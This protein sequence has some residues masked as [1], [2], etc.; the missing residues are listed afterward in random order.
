VSLPVC[1][2]ESAFGTVATMRRK[3]TDHQRPCWSQ[4]AI[5]AGMNSL[6][7]LKLERPWSVCHRA[8]RSTVTPVSV[9]QSAPEITSSREGPERLLNS[10]MFLTIR[11]ST[12]F[13]ND[14]FSSNVVVVCVA[15]S[16][17]MVR[18]TCENPFIILTANLS[19]SGRKQ[20]N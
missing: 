19:I 4:D 12:L 9:R 5:R 7:P 13:I 6:D 15:L 1:L 20:E 8:I 10:V 18:T 16:I 3:P 17:A 14:L 2:S 11:N